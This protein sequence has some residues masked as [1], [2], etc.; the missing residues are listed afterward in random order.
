MYTFISV[1]TMILLYFW[2]SKM[3]T[4]FTKEFLL[5]FPHRVEWLVLDHETDAGLEVYQSSKFCSANLGKPEW[6]THV[7]FYICNISAAFWNMVT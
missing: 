3:S 2:P 6:D 4:V 1:L 5:R 7:I